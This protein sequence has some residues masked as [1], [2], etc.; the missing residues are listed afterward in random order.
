MTPTSHRGGL[1]VPL[2]S[3]A[4]T[5]AVLVSALWIQRARDAWPFPS[6]IEAS[7]VVEAQ[8]P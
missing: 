4:T 1:V 7:S 5:A 6:S 8:E 3:V 2:V